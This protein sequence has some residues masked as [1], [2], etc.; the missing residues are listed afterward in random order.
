MLT[1]GTFSFSEIHVANSVPKLRTGQ[2]P[3]VKTMPAQHWQPDTLGL[4][5]EHN[6]KSSHRQKRQAFASSHGFP[7]LG[8]AHLESLIDNSQRIH[9]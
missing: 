1:Y 9:I 3:D 8:S 2:L 4:H 5:P 7:S 6:D